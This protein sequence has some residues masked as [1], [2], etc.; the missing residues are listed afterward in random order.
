MSVGVKNIFTN[1]ELTCMIGNDIS[2]VVI[3]CV[4]VLRA[5]VIPL[6]V[7]GCVSA[8]LCAHARVHYFAR[9]LTVTVNIQTLGSNVAV[10]LAGSILWW[11][12]L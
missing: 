5:R 10:A 1:N 2:L 7:T 8:L 11:G 9:Y 3:C 12:S 4:S 6:V